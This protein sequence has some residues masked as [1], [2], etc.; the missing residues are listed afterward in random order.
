MVPPR[1]AGTP[2]AVRAAGV[3]F[4]SAATIHGPWHASITCAS[5]SMILE[6][7]GEEGGWLVWR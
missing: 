6:L 7:A 4:Q 2:A 5:A 3:Q 1:R